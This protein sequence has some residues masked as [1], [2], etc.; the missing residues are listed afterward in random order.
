[1]INKVIKFCNDSL[2]KAE[3]WNLNKQNQQ[4]HQ[5]VNKLETINKYLIPNETNGNTNTT[6]SPNVTSP[7][8]NLNPTTTTTTTTNTTI[9][10]NNNPSTNSQT[11]KKDF[12]TD[13]TVI[14]K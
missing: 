5:L 9:P 2:D 12:N 14:E 4:T 11:L 1:M 13:K 10:N 6:N 8:S 3:T 7:S